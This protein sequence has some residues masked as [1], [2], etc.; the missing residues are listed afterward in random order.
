MGPL[1]Y[2]ESEQAI[3]A[4]ATAIRLAVVNFDIEAHNLTGMYVLLSWTARLFQIR[5]TQ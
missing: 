2:G 1:G 3:D 5:L 4:A